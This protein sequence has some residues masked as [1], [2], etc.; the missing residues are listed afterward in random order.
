[1]SSHKTFLSYFKNNSRKAALDLKIDQKGTKGDQ[2]VIKNEPKLSKK[3]QKYY[4]MSDNQNKQS[5]A[6]PSLSFSKVL[7]NG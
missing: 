6:V 4:V 3:D 5:L 2:K 7:N 1:M